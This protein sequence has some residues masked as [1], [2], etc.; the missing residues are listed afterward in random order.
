[1]LG[2]QIDDGRDVYFEHAEYDGSQIPTR[3]PSD[4]RPGQ[5]GV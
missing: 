5:T 1:M 4:I 3:D 2:E